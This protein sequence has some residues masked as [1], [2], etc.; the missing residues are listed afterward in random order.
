[1]NPVK[2]VDLIISIF[3]FGVLGGLQ[4]NNFLCLIYSK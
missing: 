2:Y 3:I 4:Y 1:M